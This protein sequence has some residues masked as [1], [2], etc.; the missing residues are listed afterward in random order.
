MKDLRY[1]RKRIDEIDEKLMELFEERMNIV[2]DVARYKAEN[3]LPI[4]HKDREDE[5]IRKNVDRIKNDLLKKHAK[6]MLHELMDISKDYQCENIGKREAAL[7]KGREIRLGFQG[8]LGSFGEEALIKYFGEDYAKTNYEEFEDVFVALKFFEIDYGV[9]PIENSSTGSITKV[10]DLLKKYNF[11]IVGETQLKIEQNLLGVKGSKIS[12]LKE[13][14]SHNQGFEQSSEY[15]KTLLDVKNIPYHN[16]AIS[17]KYVSECGDK[18]KGAIAGLRAAKIYNLD[19]LKKDINN[20]KENNTRF[21]VIGRELESNELC[22]KLTI[23]FSVLNKAGSLYKQLE[24]FSEKGINMIKIE[25]RPMGNGSFNYFFYVD[26]DGN[27]ENKEVSEALDI[28]KNSTEDFRILG[29]YKR[30]G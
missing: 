11:H 2:V 27:L 19:I 28:I 12:D 22:D 7:S 21:V 23:A 8:D 17:A 26:I 5:V 20:A 3:N 29:A 4:F 15:L 18:T 25:S 13:I 16:T 6:K 10:Y 14:Y 24:V 1:C 30:Q 9:L